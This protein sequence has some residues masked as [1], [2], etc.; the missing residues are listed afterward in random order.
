MPIDRFTKQRFEDA[1]P[2]HK[3]LG[4][5]LW[6]YGGFEGE[7][8]YNIHVGGDVY[9]RV[10]SSVDASGLAGDT[11]ENS[12]RCYL[13]SHDNKPLSNKLQ[14]YV[15]RVAGW[16]VRL[17]AQLTEL[18]KMGRNIV[19]PCNGPAKVD[20][21]IV[22]GAFCHSQMKVFL[23]KNGQHA[24]RH[25]RKCEKCGKFEWLDQLKVKAA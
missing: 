8:F 11:G 4:H 2:K 25:F 15:T 9:I 10:W 6:T 18:W 7:H 1:L 14:T 23:C 17:K 20:G 21:R 22:S 19:T 16:E 5:N 3:E 12:I 13:V 24:G